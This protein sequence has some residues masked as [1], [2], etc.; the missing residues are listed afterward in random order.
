VEKQ[1]QDRIQNLIAPGVLTAATEL[2]LTNAIYFKGSWAAPFE[3][4]ATEEQVFHLST[5]GEAKAAM[6]HRTANYRYAEGADFQ[7]V[8]L[9]YAGNELAMIILLPHAADGLPQLEKEFVSSTKLSVYLDKFDDEKVAVSIPK[10]R[11][12]DSFELAPALISLGME[13]AF[14]G[15]ADFSGMTGMKGLYLSNVIHKA[16]IEVNE[17]GTEAAAATAPVMVGSI[18]FRP[19]PPKVFDANRPFLIVIRD[20]KSG[21]ILFMGRLA[22]PDGPD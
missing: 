12:T 13:D 21:A 11:M 17:E 19:Q 22:K 1:T 8:K 5:G 14:G 15:R 7:A 16:F 20:E 2:V 10:F 18:A 6:M 9:P 3:K 4:A